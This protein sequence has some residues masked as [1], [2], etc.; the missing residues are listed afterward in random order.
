M[1]TQ[2]TQTQEHTGTQAQNTRPDP[3]ITMDLMSGS[4]IRRVSS[5]D[6]AAIETASKALLEASSDNVTTAV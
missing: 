6:I 3:V 2:S 5:A 1:L 4:S